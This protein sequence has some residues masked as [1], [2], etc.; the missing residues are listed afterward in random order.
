[1]KYAFIADIH[2]NL[3]ALEAV[4]D[5]IKKHNVDIIINCGDSIYGPL[6][7]EETAGILIN[8]NIIS[9]LGNGD[10][11]LITDPKVTPT[12]AF[13][14]SQISERTIDWIKDM[15]M[16]YQDDLVIVFHAK[17]ECNTEY[18][19]EEVDNGEVKLRSNT[20]ILKDLEGIKQKIV[21]CGHSHIE[22]IQMVEDVMLIN[23]GSVGLP[24]YEDDIPY[25]KME[26]FNPFAKY[27][28]MENGAVEIRFIKY[29]YMSA[30]KQ[31]AKNGRDDWAK[32]I[33]TGRV[34]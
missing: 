11:K 19:S 34:S 30:S 28:I 29:D 15:K 12:F 14:R 26:T 20:A 22:R 13:T 31:A 33:I 27:I 18:L 4:L 32:W 6:W 9:V 17:P 2:G 8:N 25:H 7:P 21:V 24:A 16:T 3:P 1:M 23:A 10:E 5:D